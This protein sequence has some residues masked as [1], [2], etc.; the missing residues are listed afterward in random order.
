MTIEP[1]TRSTRGAKF[2][3]ADLHLHTP[4]S[5]DFDNGGEE[6]SPDD[7]VD[8]LEEAGIDLVAI[9]DHDTGSWYKR[10]REGA[11]ARN[12][13]VLP[14]VEITT[15]GGGRHEVHVLAIF[16]PENS[17]AVDAVLA[18][19]GLLTTDQGD[20][21]SDG[22]IWTIC[23]E[24][25]SH[26][27]LPILAHIDTTCGALDEHPRDTRT[28]RRIFDEDNVAALEA[29]DPESIE[30]DIGDFAFIRSSDAHSLDDVGSRVTYLKMG[31]P[32]FEGLRTA[33]KDPESRISLEEPTYS[34]PAITGLR[35]DG[36]FFREKELMLNRNLNCLIG[37]KGTGKSCVVE[38]IRYALDI[39]PRS[40]RISEEYREKIA[41]TLYDG[42]LVE[43]HIETDEGDE[44]VVQREF[45]ANPQIFRLDGREVALTIDEF[46]EEF[47][48]IEIYSQRELLE[49]ALD[50][51][52]QLDLLDSYFDL[53]TEKDR[54]E[55]LKSRLLKNGNSINQLEAEREEYREQLTNV[56][57]LR[58]NIQ[59]LE[60][61]GV[62][63]YVEGEENW[64]T[65]KSV[66]RRIESRISEFKESID[67]IDSS[68]ALEAPERPEVQPNEE[69]LD[70]AYR[71]LQ[72]IQE[73]ANDHLES[74]RD[75]LETA[76]EVINE[77]RDRW[78]GRYE[79]RQAELEDLAE[80]I[81]EEID[82]DIMDYFE[83]KARERELQ[84]VEENLESVEEDIEVLEGA[85]E[86]LFDELEDA[87]SAVS[88]QR[89]A[90]ITNLN[91]N[92]D[93]VR[94]R[95]NEGQDRSPYIEWLRDR[96]TGSNLQNDD[97][98]MIA[99]EFG[100][101]ELA[102]IVRD[103]NYDIVMDAGLT[104]TGAHNLIDHDPL[105]DSIHELELQEIRDEPVIQILDG[106]GG[107]K[108]LDNM[109]DGQRCTSLLSIAMLE[110][111]VPLVI[112]QPED[113]LDNEFI[114][115]TVV[116]L[117]REIKHDRQII[118]V[119]HNANIPVLGD[120]EL[121]VELRSSGSNGHFSSRGS[122]DDPSI[123]TRVQ[124]VL[125]GG[126][127]AFDMRI[128]KYGY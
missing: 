10:V 50:A 54:C 114:Y 46:K 51:K 56:D 59:R 92:L 85:R 7:Y 86:N 106:S 110:R 99:E 3:K 75:D 90:G 12:I 4:G 25:R 38:H 2:Y 60:D 48:E 115:T 82:V 116:Q 71:E 53:Q 68:S 94:V 107:W 17:N 125:E 100:P 1:I 119:T 121:I 15:P 13:E 23:Q 118:S 49:I 93:E 78:D 14:G 91:S 74:L 21:V 101:R 89:R 72:N 30:E 63:E 64:D 102:R 96:L 98:K 122:I 36:K 27:G 16:P 113:M 66:L 45:D 35:V 109:S 77:L 34:H 95:L 111:E 108:P 84:E 123:T 6:I 70:G 62:S 9:T 24:I 83:L 105:R 80:A 73:T 76:T 19:Q 65:E 87:R 33:L 67:E 52:S 117:I 69:L 41:A 58:E 112:D 32:S 79:N 104:E 26:E 47:F 61:R 81:Q 5:H 43:V 124:Q 88:E 39:D 22:N 20:A 29:I 42:G 11:E 55:S 8:A 57:V 18:S 128:E 127:Q 44:Y 103:R 97:R 31:E 37:G 40:R 120:A 126:E 28:R